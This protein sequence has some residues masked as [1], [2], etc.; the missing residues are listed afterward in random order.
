MFVQ[1]RALTA[2][3]VAGRKSFDIGRQPPR[4][5][6]R[7]SVRSPLAPSSRPRAVGI[8]SEA[9]SNCVVAGCP[10]VRVWTEQAGGAAMGLCRTGWPM[11]VDG[12]RGANSLGLAVV[13]GRGLL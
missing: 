2:P 12:S 13:L 9:V 5:N 10:G 8:P 7:V 11:G 6:R 1:K 4:E 3:T